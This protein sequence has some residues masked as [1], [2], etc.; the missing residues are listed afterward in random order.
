VQSGRHLASHENGTVVHI[1]R[2]VKPDM[3]E[4]INL[5]YMRFWGGFIIK[6]DIAKVQVDAKLSPDRANGAVC[7]THTLHRVPTTPT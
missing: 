4:L 7:D 3:G 6:L 1:M 2:V 5:I